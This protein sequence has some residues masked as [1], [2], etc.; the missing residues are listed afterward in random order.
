MRVTVTGTPQDT[1]LPF[2]PAFELDRV[3][4]PSASTR[5]CPSEDVLLLVPIVEF[6]KPI[7]DLS[8]FVSYWVLTYFIQAWVN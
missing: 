7:E 4:K 3:K 2:H 5:L 1:A 8:T 6:G